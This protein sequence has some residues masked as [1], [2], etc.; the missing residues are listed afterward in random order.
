MNLSGL[1]GRIAWAVLYGLVVFIVT[2]IIGLLFSQFGLE[3]IGGVLTKY[4]ALLGLLAAVVV[5]LTRSTP[6][7]PI[8]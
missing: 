2:T 1:A 3:A 7:K 4:A 8:V 6:S 5:F